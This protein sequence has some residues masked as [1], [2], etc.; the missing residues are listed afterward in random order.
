MAKRNLSKTPKRKQLSRKMKRKTLNRKK[1]GKKSIGRNVAYPYYPV[2]R[3]QTL[4]NRPSSEANDGFTYIFIFLSMIVVG[5]V[6]HLAHLVHRP[7]GGAT[8]K[9]SENETFQLSE[10]ET[11]QLLENF[12]SC[13]VN[14]NKFS[15]FMEKVVITENMLTINYLNAEE[16]TELKKDVLLNKYIKVDDSKISFNIDK[17]PKTQDVIEQFINKIRSLDSEKNI[18]KIECIN[19]KVDKIFENR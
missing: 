5:S 13:F 9:L 4:G 10:N 6:A 15:E 12:K 17:I 1:G 16:I 8:F 14:E 2:Y 11:F 19:K 3:S 18:V 7:S